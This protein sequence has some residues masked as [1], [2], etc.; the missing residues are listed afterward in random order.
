MIKEI[1]ELIKQLVKSPRKRKILLGGLLICGGLIY[2][3]QTFFKE[4]K[5]GNSY[6]INT[7]GG[8]IQGSG[9]IQGEQNKIFNSDTAK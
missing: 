4:G 1:Y 5:V 3:Y 2:C 8:N 6:N 7:G 9:I